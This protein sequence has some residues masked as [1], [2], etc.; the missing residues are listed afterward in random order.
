MLDVKWVGNED[1]FSNQKDRIMSIKDFTAEALRSFIQDH[2]EKDYALIDVRQPGEYEQGHIPG[3]KL[4]PLPELV[5][6]MEALPTDKQLVFYCHSGARSMA[7]ASMA[8][9]EGAGAGDLI[10]LNGG[11]MAWDGGTAEDYPQVELFNWHA[12]PS[13]MLLTAMNLEKGALNFYSQVHTRHQDQPWVTVFADLAKAEMGHAR[14]VY[15]LWRQIE[16]D[17]QDFESVFDGLSGEVL[18]GGMRLDAALEN[19]AALKGPLC[20]RLIE[21]ALKIEYAAFDLYHTMADRV[22]ATDAQQAFITIAQAEKA[23][24]QFL[25][26]AISRCTA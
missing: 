18:E 21:M 3:A 4:L 14:T 11:M 5:Q 2:H 25:S 7:A 17:G 10:N 19:L 1:L 23:H 16:T 13:D 15:H 24:M 22:T 9:E 8:E 12:S 6:S 26:K 20:L